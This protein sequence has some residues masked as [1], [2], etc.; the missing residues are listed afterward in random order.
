MSTI[1]VH[2]GD[3]LPGDAWFAF[4]T[5]SLRTEAHRFLGEKIPVTKLVSAEAVTQETVKKLA[6]TL[7]WGAVG[8]VLAGPLGLLA[9]ALVGGSKSKV[10]F[11]LAVEDGRKA[12]AT[13]DSATYAA[14][15][16]AVVTN[17][18]E[19]PERPP[20]LTSSE[21]RGCSDSISPRPTAQFACP[22][23]SQRLQDDRDIAGQMVSCPYCQQVFQMPP[24]PPL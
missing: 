13:A 24:E 17:Q 15:L 22:H 1:Q 4:G 8:V 9:G 23:C 12:L 11:I 18:Q 19:S 2:G 21:T 14:L 5:L 7:G 20:K 16:G 6:G 3:F 10:T